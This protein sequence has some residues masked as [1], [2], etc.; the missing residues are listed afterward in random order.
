MLR[1]LLRPVVGGM[2]S[3]VGLGAV[4]AIGRYP[5]TARAN[6]RGNLGVLAATMIVLAVPR[7]TAPLYLTLVLIGLVAGIALGAR[8]PA[9]SAPQP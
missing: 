4:L 6:I 7:V 5:R 9:S 8:Q 3:W 1:V 2:L